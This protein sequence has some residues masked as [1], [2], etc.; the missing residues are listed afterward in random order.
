MDV[1]DVPPLF[2]FIVNQGVS[3]YTKP[4]VL[5]LVLLCCLYLLKRV[6]YK[7][8]ADRKHHLELSLNHLFEGRGSLK[9]ESFI[10]DTFVVMLLLT[11]NTIWTQSET[12]T[13]AE[14]R[15]IDLH[16]L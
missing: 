15:F 5:A 14:P 4:F 9:I 12:A 8:F 10:C 2:L 1:V 6:H 3:T 13:Q 7:L 16:K 11:N